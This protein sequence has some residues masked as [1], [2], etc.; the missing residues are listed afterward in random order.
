MTLP[1][2]SPTLQKTKHSRALSKATRSP[3]FW[4]LDG[5]VVVLVEKTLYK[6]HRSRLSRPNSNYF[7]RLF[8]DALQT[9][10]NKRISADV[11]GDTSEFE[12]PD[13]VEH[14][15]R[16]SGGLM[17]GEIVDSCPVYRIAGVSAEDFECLL[18]AWEMGMYV[19]PACHVYVV[20]SLF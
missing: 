1:L 19:G 11:D 6:L 13:I 20:L 12:E 5:S 14:A 3:N 4:Y 10:S 7:A 9:P 15:G 16:C 8:G 18:T 17:E 2:G